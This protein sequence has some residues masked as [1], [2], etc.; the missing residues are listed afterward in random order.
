MVLCNDWHCS[1]ARFVGSRCGAVYPFH[2]ESSSLSVAVWRDGVRM[3]VVDVR[4]IYYLIY[5][6]WDTSLATR[7]SCQMLASLL[8]SGLIGTIQNGIDEG[9][10]DDD[11]VTMTINYSY[12]LEETEIFWFCLFGFRSI[13]SFGLF[14]VF[15]FARNGHN[16]IKRG[17][18]SART[19]LYTR[20]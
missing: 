7:C 20:Q 15:F 9:N 18:C 17:T 5:R 6:V 16:Q 11:D 2:D 8:L 1:A 14:V 19:H 3:D 10:D 13:F 4:F 12:D